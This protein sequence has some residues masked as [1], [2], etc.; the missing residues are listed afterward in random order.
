[1][2]VPLAYEFAKYLRGIPAHHYYV[3]DWGVNNEGIATRDNLCG[4]RAC[5]AGHFVLYEGGFLR[6]A[7]FY[8]KYGDYVEALHYAMDR[9]DLSY[10][11]GMALFFDLSLETPA[12]AADRLELLADWV[13]SHQL[14]EATVED[15]ELAT[16]DLHA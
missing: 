6:E 11:D 5:I 8:D 16:S 7:N 10:R 4:T 12:A 14:A 3:R 1:M 15:E 13:K 9:L 2:N